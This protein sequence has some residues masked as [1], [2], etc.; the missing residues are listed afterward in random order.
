LRGAAIALAV[1]AGIVPG[2]HSVRAAPV[3]CPNV[4]APNIQFGK[5]VYIDKSRPGG[6]PVSQ[7]AQDGSIIVAGH[8]STSLYY[9]NPE[10]IGGA[11]DYYSGYT[12]QTY[13]WRSGDHGKNWK[14]IEAIAGI[15][16][17]TIAS[18]G[19]S[20]PDFAMDD[21]GT[22]YGTEIN[23]VNVSVYSS[24]D[25]GRSFP[26]GNPLAA[27]GDRPWLGALEPGEVFLIINTPEQLLRSTD[28]GATFSQLQTNFVPDGHMF[29]DPLNPKDGLIGPDGGGAA[30]SKDDGE[31]WDRYGLSLETNEGFSTVAVDRAGWIYSASAGGY[32]GSGAGAIIPSTEDKNPNA[33]VE[34]SYFNRKT[35]KWARPMKIPVP[36]GDALWPWLAAGDDGRVVIVWLQNVARDPSSFYVY[37]AYSTNGHGSYVRC[38]DGRL[39][40]KNPVFRVVNASGRPVHVGDI[41]LLGTACNID[42]EYDRRLGDYFTVN[43]DNDGRIFVVVP[44]TRLRSASGSSKPVANPLFIRQSGGVPAFR[45][46]VPPE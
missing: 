7:V 34:Y 15:G 23:L 33:L 1:L 2:A 38:S 11:S 41:C 27:S 12:N 13:V 24:T 18:S 45:R 8:A 29:R 28:G 21:A 16:A 4:A 10:A 17:H 3:R 6:E 26:N 37:A 39:H 36:R 44:D 9:K 43:I 5:P 42:P 14:R 40:F 22:I 30:I 25:D 32:E 46:P 35:K 31:T 19:F 20:D